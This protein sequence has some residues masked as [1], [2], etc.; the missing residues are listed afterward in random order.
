MKAL[1]ILKELVE[2][3]SVSGRENEIV[4]H[5][6]EVLYDFEPSVFEKYNTKNILINQDADVWVVTHVDTV[7]IKKTF[8]FDGVYAY[9]TGCCDA[10]AS[11]TAI[12]LALEE[13]EEPNFGVALLSDEEE[14]GLGSKA[15][16]EEFDKRKAIVMEPTELKIANR[17]Y[18]CLEIDVEIGGVSVHGAYPDKGINAIEKAIDVINRV[19]NLNYLYLVQR[20]EGGSYEYVVPDRC[21][22]RI[23]LLIPPEDDVNDVERKVTAI[24]KNENFTVV[25]K[26][27]G[28]LSGEVT[29]LIERAVEK[30]SLP[31]VYTEMRSWTDAINFV[32][33]GW[34]VVVFGPGELHLCHTEK[35]R[36]K[37]DDIL[38]AKDVLVALNDVLGMRMK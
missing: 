3:E 2:I 30:A 32:N 25:E 22:L 12:I 21:Y 35:E 19:K 13:I 31:V 16:V 38:K 23:D 1:S 24:F 26:A 27:K 4:S 28:F 34:D 17:H 29:E 9:G 18:G 15:V 6:I 37:I 33:A 11:I 10:K 8:E 7:Q 20:I 5:L 36:I 14:G